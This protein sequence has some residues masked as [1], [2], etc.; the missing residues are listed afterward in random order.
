MENDELCIIRL[1]DCFTAGYTL[2]QYC[3]DNEFKRPLFVAAQKNWQ[4]VWEIYVQFAYDKRL[5]P[6]FS[7]YDSPQNFGLNYSVE[8]ILGPLQIKSLSESVVRD[9]DAIICLT[10]T[11]IFSSNAVIYLDALTHHFI[12]KAYCE[13]PLLHFLQR[14]PNVHLIVTNFPR[15]DRPV[16]EREKQLCSTSIQ[17]IHARLSSAGET[18]AT[19]YEH[20]HFLRYRGFLRQND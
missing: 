18:I 6:K 14:N 17:Q 10:T 2:P 3:I 11:K 7:F 1:R 5:A 15:I 8:C 9:C 12:R 4:L 20:V 13:I 16:T 19:P